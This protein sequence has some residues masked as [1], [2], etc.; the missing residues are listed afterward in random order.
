MH[1]NKGTKPNRV[2]LMVVSADAL[3]DPEA[4]EADQML[5]T[6]VDKRV[7]SAHDTPATEEKFYQHLQ[8]YSCLKELFVQVNTATKHC[9][10]A[11]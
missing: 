3:C 9:V 6:D 10:H 2:R 1:T 4:A 5:A 8:M 11:H 7:G